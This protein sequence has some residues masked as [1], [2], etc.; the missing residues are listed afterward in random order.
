ITLAD[1]LTIHD[2]N[3]RFSG[4][5]TRTL[6]QLIPDFKS[7]RR[8]VLA[9]RAIVSGGRHWLTLNTDL[10]FDDQRAGR[11]RVIAVGDVGFP[12][13]GVRAS[14]LRLQMLPVQVELARTWFP[15]LPISGVVTG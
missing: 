1:T 6:E 8:G 11:S 4:V 7:P 5:D 13:R 12:G 14:N 15:T 3:L 9:G 10:T 2:T